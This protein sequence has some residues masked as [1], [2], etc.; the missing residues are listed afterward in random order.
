MNEPEGSMASCVPMSITV[1]RAQTSLKKLESI[2][3][4]KN[5]KLQML[6]KKFQ[7]APRARNIKLAK[8]IFNL[9]GEIKDLSTHRSE[10][11]TNLMKILNRE[12]EQVNNQ[13]KRRENYLSRNNVR[14]S[15]ALEYIQSENMSKDSLRTA[16][17]H[18]SSKRKDLKY[19]NGLDSQSCGD[20]LM[21]T[22]ESDPKSAMSFLKSPSRTDSL[23]NFESSPML[24]RVKLSESEEKAAPRENFNLS[25]SYQKSASQPT[26]LRKSKRKKKK[27]KILREAIGEDEDIPPKP[28]RRAKRTK[29]D[30]EISR[31]ISLDKA[32]IK[33]EEL[34]SINKMDNFMVEFKRK[35]EKN[36]NVETF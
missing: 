20:S 11:L 6:C 17:D 9:E 7:E 35:Y 8:T 18:Y 30:H 25:E 21:T 3:K 1:T 23:S 33:Q 32:A 24:K 13:T 12:L 29:V 14:L 34:I 27:S 16:S 5:R 31:I 28:I 10:A 15:T 19:K 26:P 36:E 2:L 22:S 4:Q